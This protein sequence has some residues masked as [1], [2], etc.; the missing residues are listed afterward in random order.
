MEIGANTTIDR[1]RFGATRID[2][3]AKLDNLI[4]V[5][6]NC[7]VG[8]SA[9][10]AAQV[11]IAGS[12]RVGAG[13]L[14]A[15]QVGVSG[16]AEIGPGARIGGQAGVMSFLEGGKEYIGSPALPLGD[17][18]RFWALRKRLPDLVKRVRDLE[19]RLEEERTS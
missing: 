5:G 17:M 4:H 8:G 12:S 14:L 11:G 1:A 16:H 18:M 9:A 2:A 6:H 7:E 10:I 19:R 3:G 15:G 13:S